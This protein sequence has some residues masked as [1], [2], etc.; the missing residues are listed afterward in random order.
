MRVYLDTSVIGGYLRDVPARID[1]FERVK[2]KGHKY[3][4]ST[5]VFSELACTSDRSRFAEQW[6]V[7]QRLV[8]PNCYYK[9]PRELVKCEL[10]RLKRSGVC[11]L[12]VPSEEILQMLALVPG[13]H[14][15]TRK[16]HLA[17]GSDFSKFNRSSRNVAGKIRDALPNDFMQCWARIKAVGEFDKACQDICQEHSPR[18]TSDELDELRTEPPRYRVIFTKILTLKLFPYCQAK[19]LSCPS[20]GDAGDLRHAVVA[21]YCDI[22]LTRDIR[23][24]EFL[25][26]ASQLLPYKVMSPEMFLCGDPP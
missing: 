7:L 19:G 8:N 5:D 25:N 12:M 21:A 4:A 20:K 23:F 22:L 18:L 14:S 11:S 1:D 26:R 24:I 15:E 2:A 9:Q 3:Y 6:R 13:S 10:Q 16:K 17:I